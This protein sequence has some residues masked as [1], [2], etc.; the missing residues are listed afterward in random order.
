MKYFFWFLTFLYFFIF[1]V[2]L[3]MYEWSSLMS[4]AYSGMR[5]KSRNSPN[6]QKPKNI[7]NQTTAWNKKIKKMSTRIAS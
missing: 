2:K 7:V 6:P 4:W 3:L 1:D 5:T